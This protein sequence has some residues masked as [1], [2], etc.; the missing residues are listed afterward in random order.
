M[1]KHSN[2]EKK[3][4]NIAVVN[5]LG[6]LD[7]KSVPALRRNIEALIDGGCRRVILNMSDVDYVDSAGMGLILKELRRMR[8]MGGLLSLTNVRPRVYRSMAIMRMI[9]YMPVMQEGGKGKVSELSPTVLPK[10]RTTFPVDADDLGSARER[11]GELM[12]E[13]PFSDDDVF[14]MTL[15]C[16]EAIGNAVDHTCA[17][18]VLTTFSAYQDRV[19]VDVADCGSGFE[20]RPD[21][22]PPETGPEAER[23]RGIKLMRMLADAVSIAPKPSGVGTVV[24]LVKLLPHGNGTLG[25]S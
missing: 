23:G 22:E 19:V 17:Q 20:L 21:E 25:V 2:M 12:R 16:G 5:V 8:K 1:G 18:G 13:L 7:V 14:D 4:P 9:D 10:W 11:V 3:T 6:D 24:R 15:A